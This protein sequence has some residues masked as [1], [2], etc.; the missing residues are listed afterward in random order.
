M[1][2]GSPVN[3]G[4]MGWLALAAA[5]ILLIGMVTFRKYKYGFSELI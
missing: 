4:E 3:F 1:V 5:G 2:F